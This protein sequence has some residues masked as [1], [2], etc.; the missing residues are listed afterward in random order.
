RV[1][2][3]NAQFEVF[4]GHLACDNTSRSEMV[5]PVVIDNELFGV[6]EIEGQ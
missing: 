1:H 5:G 2:L 6:L 4:P 3:C